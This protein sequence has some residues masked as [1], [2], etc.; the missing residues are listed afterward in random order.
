M[1][2]AS[3][4]AS[5]I[6][7]SA[8]AG[9]YITTNTSQTI[10]STGTKTWQGAQV[11]QAGGTTFQNGFTAGTTAITNTVLGF[12]STLSSN[13]QTQI[14]NC[15]KTNTANTFGT[16]QQTITNNLRLDG[17]LLVGTAGGTNIK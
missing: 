9:S 15:A 16:G 6:P 14:G 13:A 3:I 2:G 4:T 1:S 5:T 12:I 8:L 7:N 11:F 17:S 10:A